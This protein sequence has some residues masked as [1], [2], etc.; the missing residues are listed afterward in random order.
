[1]KESYP[2]N[3][4]RLIG[5][6][7]PMPVEFQTPD[8]SV[9]EILDA[10]MLE[11]LFGKTVVRDRT[12]AR[13]CVAGLWLIAGHLDECHSIAQAI[14]TPDGSYWHAIMHRREG[15][16]S[17]SKYWY[18]RAGDHPIFPKIF[19][20]SKKIGGFHFAGIQNWDPFR[21]VDFCERAAKEKS[22]RQACIEIQTAEWEKLFQHC[23]TKATA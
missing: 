8:E 7:L 16:Y 10:A 5:R 18:R 13:L 4:Q 22:L 1:M 21:F 12:S 23:Y 11:R 19:E 14:E 2:P 17:N 20:V 6:F 15:D 3:I 9:R